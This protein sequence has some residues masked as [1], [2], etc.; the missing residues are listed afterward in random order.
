M[1]RVQ[2]RKSFDEAFKARHDSDKENAFSLDVDFVAPP[3]VTVLFG[4][5]GSGKT[6]TLKIIAGL[7]RPDEGLISAGDALLFDSSNRIDLPVRKRGVG[8]VFQAP[9]LFPHLSSLQNV[10][11]A[12]NEGS[13]R[14]KSARAFALLEQF[15]VGHVASRLP[16]QISGGEAQRVALARALASRPLILLLDEPLSAL[17]VSTKESI[18]EDLKRVNH[19]LRLPV[20]YVTH[21]REEVFALGERAL[22]FERGRI[23]ARGTPSELFASPSS[24]T[25]ARLAGF[26]NIFECVIER[27]DASAGTMIVKLLEPGAESCNIEVP[28][29]GNTAGESLHV[30]LHSGDIL[31]ASE[32]P[33]GLSAR[34]VFEGIVQS[35]EERD[36]QKLVRVR[37][38]VVWTASVTRQTAVNM[39]LET[40]RRV[41]I[42]FKTFSCRLIDPP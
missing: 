4:P 8:Y 1:L 13:R 22:I 12:V 35:I 17:D 21:S 39:H 7:I 38:G 32:E 23:V 11:F 24:R 15:G 40:G 31:L 34:N 20:L 27:L 28:L 42:V 14:E 26:E 6:T 19:E 3:G 16:R 30:A 41:W 5:S 9:T 29:G 33:R 37:S 10:E 36:G 25:F 2:V 18:I